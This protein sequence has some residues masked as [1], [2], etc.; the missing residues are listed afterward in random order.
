MSLRIEA[1][2]G[3]ALLPHVAA[4][5]RLRA[6]VFADWPYV[7]QGEAE[8]EARYIRKYM[9]GPGAAIILA[10]DGDAVVG[11][12]TCQPMV[13]SHG[14]VKSA[15]ERAGRDPAQYCYF[16]ES[17]LLPAYRGQGA[18]VA[19]FTAREAH[20][21]SLGLPNA[22]FCGV[23]RNVNDPRKPASYTPLDDFW[24]KRG[25]THHPEISCIF[26]WLEIGDTKETPHALSFWIKALA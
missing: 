4:L 25:Y 2:T 15:F 10:L 1:F 22:T 14:P 12:A 3:A 24:R 21:R 16:G 11:A 6:A 18:G 19:F 20:A 13:E 5:S 9:E 8:D 7:Y 23:V 26:D 17:V